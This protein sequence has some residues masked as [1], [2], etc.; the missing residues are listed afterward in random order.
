MRVLDGTPI[1]TVSTA[2]E[3]PLSEAAAEAWIPRTCFKNGPPSQVGVELE[4]LVVD[5]REK[6]GSATMYP[7]D[8]YAQL[9]QAL[10][11]GGL[12]GRLTVEPGGQVELSSRPGPD[13]PQTLA[14][15]QRDLAALRRRAARRGAALV[16]LGVDPFR[17]GHRII[18]EPRYAAMERYFEQWGSAGRTMMRSTASVQVNVEAGVSTTAAPHPVDPLTDIS[19]RWELLHA[20]G[21]ALVAA[22]ANSSHQHG[23]P[24]GWQSTRQAAWLS[25][26][27][28]RTG[29]PA[30]R[31]GES[32]PQAYARWA[33]DAPLMLVRRDSGSWTAPRG[34]TFRDWI[35]AGRSAIPD[36][37]PPTSADLDYHLSTLFPQV[38]ARGHLEVRYVDAQ[39][40]DCWTVPPAVITAL[41][42]DAAA[43]GQARDVCDSIEGRWR[44]AARTGLADPALA[45]AARGV[46]QIA[47]GALRRQPGCESIAGEVEAYYERW[48]G[49]GRC[50]ADDPPAEA[51]A[52]TE[53]STKAPHHQPQGDDQR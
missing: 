17:V 29:V 25:L 27:P 38:R 7:P 24:T 26:D 47:V 5:A 43:A 20:V 48:T 1:N 3:P 21:P 9:L 11:D 40:G 8:S 6:A 37:P 42:D 31:R 50:P 15:V 51:I 49:R 14:V 32:V 45:A 19:Q 13:L 2:I 39:P 12:D 22:F 18:D 10:G 23:R 28:A 53:G 41:L 4:F 33:L 34:V 35:R 52:A 46:L 36:L 30:V 16:G 44:D